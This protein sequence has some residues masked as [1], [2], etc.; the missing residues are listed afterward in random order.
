MGWVHKTCTV[1]SKPMSFSRN[2]QT[3]RERVTES[4]ESLKI[5]VGVLV[6]V[7]AA[8]PCGRKHRKPTKPGWEPI[9]G[10]ADGGGLKK[11]ALYIQN[12]C[13]FLETC[14]DL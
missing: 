6:F 12:P 11:I 14:P 10:W 2:C 8:P 5:G 3:Y 4:R 1:H 13:H 7:L 9:Q